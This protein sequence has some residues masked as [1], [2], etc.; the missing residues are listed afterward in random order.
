MKKTFLVLRYEILT[1]LRRPSF[2]L[3]TFGLPLL[4]LL[5][6]TVVTI[7]RNNRTADPSAAEPSEQTDLLVEGFVDQSGLITV[8]PED[9]PPGIL[10]SYADEDAAYDA[11]ENGDITAYYI[12]PEEYV[13]NGE[14]IYVRPN[15]SPL[16]SGGQEWMMRWTLLYN[17]VGGDIE[18]ASRIWN[19]MDLEVTNISPQPEHDRY[20]SEDCSKPGYTCESNPVIRMLPMFIVVLFMIFL[21]AGS[22]IL[23]RNVSTEKQNRMMEILILSV[24]PRQMLGGKMIGLGLVTLVQLVVWVSTGYLILTMGGDTLN[25]PEEFSLPFSLVIW[26]I[27]FFLLGYALYASLMAGAGALVPRVKDIQ[28]ATW[29]LML[30]IMLSYFFAVTPIGQNDPNSALV[31]GLSLFPLTAPIIMIMR[32][33]I[34]EVPLWQLAI[35][36]VALV[37]GTTLTIRS[38]ARMFH[39]QTLLSG[40]PFSPKRYFKE[41]LNVT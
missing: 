41:L 15:Y 20:S 19:P 12:V 10:L 2:L 5:V 22:G 26:T 18:F 4:G 9:L 30:P 33:T 28:Q 36:I 39:A 1:N 35:A 13:E 17:L 14:F 29:V 38:V 27:V 23:L 7:V 24:N 8:I 34:T 32:L 40:Q 25:L 31:T 21:S 3:I 37:V 6:F 11:L 16:S